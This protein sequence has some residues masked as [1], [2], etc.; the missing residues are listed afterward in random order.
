MRVEIL[1]FHKTWKP[2]NKVDIP[3]EDADYLLKVG[4]CR[5]LEPLPEPEPVPEPEPTPEL[6]FDVPLE[7][8]AL[9]ESICKKLYQSGINTCRE[10]DDATGDIGLTKTEKKKADVA[11]AEALKGNEEYLIEDV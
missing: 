6:P 2:G 4:G 9:P 3:Q 5:P 1:C 11:I 7:S 8:V 10:Y